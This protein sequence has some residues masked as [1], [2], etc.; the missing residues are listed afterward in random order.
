VFVVSDF[1][2]TEAPLLPREAKKRTSAA[3]ILSLPSSL[4]RSKRVVDVKREMLK[5]QRE[6]QERQELKTSQLQ[7]KYQQL[8]R[9]MDQLE[10]RLANGNILQVL[11]IA[12]W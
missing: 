1:P 12:L 7:V 9:D 5:R 8:L 11:L 10:A 6:L 2:N 3:S 4:L